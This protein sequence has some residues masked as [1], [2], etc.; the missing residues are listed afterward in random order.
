MVVAFKHRLHDN[1]WYDMLISWWTDS[2][3]I[4]TQ[5]IFPN[6]K[7][8]SSWMDTGVAFKTMRETIIYPFHYTFVA[9]PEGALDEQKV[10]DYVASRRGQKFDMKGAI[11]ATAVP[12]AIGGRNRWHCSEVSF[13]ALKNGGLRTKVWNRPPESISPQNLFDILTKENQYPILKSYN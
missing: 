2:E 11:L 5:I 8:G 13:S 7:V 3:F 10:Y 4:H 1:D 12:Y 6:G 9:I